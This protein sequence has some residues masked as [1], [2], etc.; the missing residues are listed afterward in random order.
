METIDLEV[1]LCHFM[2]KVP[3]LSTEMWTFTF[4]IEKK[5]QDNSHQCINTFCSFL[6]YFALDLLKCI[7]LYSLAL[8]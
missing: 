8:K 7:Q 5:K 2:N 1:L 6:S 3:F 4:R